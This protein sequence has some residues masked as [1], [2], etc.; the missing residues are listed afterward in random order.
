MA[1]PSPAWS[2]VVVPVKKRSE[3]EMTMR[4]ASNHP[5]RLIRLAAATAIACF[6]LVATAPTSA[7]AQEEDPF[8]GLKKIDESKA[9]VAYIDPNADFSV[10]KRVAISDPY[11]AFRSNWRR[12]QNRNRIRPIT[13]GQANRIKAD[14]ASLLKEVFTERLEKDNGYKVTKEAGYDV[15]LLKP[16][17]VDL[18]IN[19]PETATAGAQASISAFYGQ[20]VLYI[21]LF[22]SVSGDIIGR[23]ADRQAADQSRHFGL[24]TEALRQA[25]ARAIFEGW[26]DQ[27]RAFLD[28]HY[29]GE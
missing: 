15:L 19:L 13:A 8:A 1:V 2:G 12:D 25:A 10:F 27:L 21:E 7:L 18:D 20:A 28:E 16:A 23:A 17:I 11:V 22:D 3:R 4:D 5:A 14:V 26:A 9:G 6:A 29:K 24:N